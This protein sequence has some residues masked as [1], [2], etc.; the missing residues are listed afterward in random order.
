M[1][2]RS[3]CSTQYVW[4]GLGCVSFSFPFLSFLQQTILTDSW[5]PFFGK[6]GIHL[7]IA[8]VCG[9]SVLSRVRTEFRRS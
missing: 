6:L 4:S 8:C 1:G 5:S 2:V 7:G 9:E 3:P